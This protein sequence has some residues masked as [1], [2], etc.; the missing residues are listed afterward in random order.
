[1]KQE[2]ALKEYVE[3]NNYGKVIEGTSEILTNC[4]LKGADA[5][6]KIST[7]FGSLDV[8]KQCVEDMTDNHTR[9]FYHTGSSDNWISV[10]NNSLRFMGIRFLV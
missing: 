8:F 7:L 2:Y 5:E 3:D 9:Y 1:M 6:N 10:E 4:N